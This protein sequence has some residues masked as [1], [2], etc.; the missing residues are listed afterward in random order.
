M[1][2]KR[3][4]E[5]GA[6]LSAA[7]G[8]GVFAVAGVAS[9]HVSIEQSEVRAGAYELVTVSVPHGCDGSPTTEVRI[10]MPES[11][12]AVTPTVN[13]NWDVEKV[14]LALDEPITDSHG[15]EITERVSEVVYTAKTPL[16]DGFRDAFTLSL[17]VPDDASGTL[18]FPTVQTC[19]EGE[20]GWIEIPAEGQ[21]PEELELP[22]PAVAVVS[23][24]G[25]SDGHGESAAET[26]GTTEVAA[27]DDGDDEAAT[28]DSG[29]DSSN[30]LAIAALVVGVLGL[31][32]GAVAIARTRKS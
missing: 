27:T 32:T 22:S 30:G 2:N 8:V 19:E 3:F 29:D 12:V 7:V 23:A 20:S 26:T 24:S 18:Y 5:R 14:M 17:R 16:L 11:I 4:I 15:A 31:G 6:I 1:F 9:A 10:Q 13:P 28:D 21:D 25:E